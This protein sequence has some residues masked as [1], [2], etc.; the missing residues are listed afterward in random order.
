MNEHLGVDGG[1]GG[2]KLIG[3]GIV[4]CGDMISDRW[5]NVK[6]NSVIDVMSWISRGGGVRERGGVIVWGGVRGGG[7]LE[8]TGGGDSD[9]CLI[10]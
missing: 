8:G 3:R 7:E 4:I 5:I 6:G 1:V 9:V 10:S 2:S